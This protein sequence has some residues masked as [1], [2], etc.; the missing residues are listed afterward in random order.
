MVKTAHPRPRTGAPVISRRSAL[1]GLG[2]AAALGLTACGPPPTEESG[3]GPAR[4]VKHKYGTTEISGRP[5]RVVTVGLTEQ[6]YVMALGVTPVGVR[7][8]FGGHDGALWPWAAE[9]LGDD[10][11]PEVLPVEELNFEQIGALRPDLILGVNSGL[12]EEEYTTLAEIAPTIAQAPDH[13]DYGAPWQ[14]IAA[15]VGTALDREAEAEALVADIEERFE[16]VRADH[17]EFAE[18]TGLLATSIEGEAWA[19]AEGPAP[20]FLTQLGFALPEKA[21]ALFTD[22]E[23]APKQVSL[24]KL[25]VLEADVLLL[26]VYD[27]PDNSVARTDVFS[28]LDA[29]KEG[30]VLEMPEMS[31][32]NGALSFGSV[33]SLPYALD[34]LVPRLVDLVDGDPGTEPAEVE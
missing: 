34:E 19:Y 3:S 7:E 9:L 4:R 1:L 12:T 33:L 28:E 15:M 27:D 16:Q 2:G 23:R 24:E 20:G 26:G 29:A 11:T 31:R 6:D 21:E 5:S 14:E 32:L 22:E 17:P 13:A 25:E 30:R 8:W 10:E 18:S